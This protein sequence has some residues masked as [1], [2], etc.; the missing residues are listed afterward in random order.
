MTTVPGLV[1]GAYFAS[2]VRE[3]TPVHLSYI[4]THIS[5]DKYN[6]K[7][8]LYA[9][10]KALEDNPEVA[11][12]SV[13]NGHDIASH[14]YRWIDYHVVGPEEEK[15]YIRKGLECIKTLTGSYPKVCACNSSAQA[16]LNHLHSQGWYYGRLSPRSHA[17]VWDVYKEKGIPLVWNSDSYA[18]SSPEAHESPED[19][20]DEGEIIGRRSILAR[21][22][23]RERR[24]EP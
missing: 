14:A 21:R 13:G 6:I 22:A 18:V 17:L 1:S 10:G 7:Y 24:S 9:V 23:R 4:C 12:S 5:L 19:K 16:T 15:E 20:V 2:S 11:K 3:F 8:T